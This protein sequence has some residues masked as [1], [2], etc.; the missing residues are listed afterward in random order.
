VSILVTC[1]CGKQTRVPA[2]MAGKHM[3]CLSCQRLLV[4]AGTASPQP[5]KAPGGRPRRAILVT[6][7]LALLLLATSLL[8]R[9]ST[10]DK[11]AGSWTI[12]PEPAHN[13]MALDLRRGG[14][15]QL[16][17]ADETTSGRW[18]ITEQEGATVKMELSFPGEPPAEALL[19]GGNSLMATFP[20]LGTFSFSRSGAGDPGGVD[21]GAPPVGYPTTHAIV[22]ALPVPPAARVTRGSGQ[23]I[24]GA[25]S[26]NY[27]LIEKNLYMGGAVP[28]PPPGT[29]ATLNLNQTE[30]SWRTDVY[31]WV[32]IPDAAPAPSLAWLQERVNFVAAQRGSR[33]TTY[34]HCA[35]GKSRSGLVTVAYV[36]S[37]HHWSR[38]KALSF[39]KSKR[40][41]TNP[42]SAFMELLVKWEQY[43][44]TGGN[45]GGNGR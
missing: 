20:G 14:T 11:V 32:P 16:Q 33:T 28:Q 38:D 12:E 3:R 6:C 9:E 37:E 36:M 34:V 43:L 27:S 31:T 18:R 39:V 22:R 5:K 21:N 7:L 29:K 35:A 42:N 4:A 41:Q 1:A 19:Q 26:A 23:S 30:D 25:N 24:P 2:G 40:P 13:G 45:G 10:Q 8:F 17:F 15:F 44:G